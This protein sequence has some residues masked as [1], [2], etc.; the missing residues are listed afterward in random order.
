MVVCCGASCTVPALRTL[1]GCCHASTVQPMPNSTT[2]PTSYTSCQCCYKIA[3]QQDQSAL[4]GHHA[5]TP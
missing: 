4:Q 1:L 3:G 5:G 2:V